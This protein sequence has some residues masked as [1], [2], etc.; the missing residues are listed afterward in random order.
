MSK[1]LDSILN[2]VPAATADSERKNIL[3]APS[4]QQASSRIAIEIPYELKKK[5]KAYIEEH[6]GETEKTIVLKGLKAIGFPIEE[7]LLKDQRRTR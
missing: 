1:Q 6:P 3:R 5:L 7:S 2:K 4:P